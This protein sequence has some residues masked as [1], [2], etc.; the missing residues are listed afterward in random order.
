MNIKCDCSINCIIYVL[1]YF[2]KNVIIKFVC[3]VFWK[4]RIYMYMYFIYFKKLSKFKYGYSI[5]V[6]IIGVFI[7]EY[8]MYFDII[9]IDYNLS[10]KGCLC[11]KG[12]LLI[13]IYVLACI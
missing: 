4:L 12:V 13:K 11:V 10:K 3:L 1:I 2:K 7:V 5:I 9:C 8:G 6:D